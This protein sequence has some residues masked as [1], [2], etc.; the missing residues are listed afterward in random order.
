[1]AGKHAVVLGRSEL[2]GRPVALLLSS[3]NATVTL[4]HSHTQNVPDI[5]RTADVLVAAIRKPEY[6]KG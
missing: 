6:V 1:M 2:V 3:L 4:C 5:V